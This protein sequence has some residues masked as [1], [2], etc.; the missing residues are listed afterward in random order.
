M[1][2]IYPIISIL[3]LAGTI[4][5]FTV[6]LCKMKTMEDHLNR[7][8]VEVTDQKVRIKSLENEDFYINSIVKA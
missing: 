4:L 2:L 6:M 7:V 1:K 8:G 5:I 3:F